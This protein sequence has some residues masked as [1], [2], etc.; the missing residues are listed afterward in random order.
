MIPYVQIIEGRP[1]SQIDPDL[2]LFRVPD[3]DAVLSGCLNLETARRFLSAEVWSKSSA[4]QDF[5]C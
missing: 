1:S 3:R 5:A 2:E 4:I